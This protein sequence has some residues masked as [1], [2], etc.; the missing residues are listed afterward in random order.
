MLKIY[1]ED[2]S[3]AE[4]QA[5]EVSDEVHI[6]RLIPALVQEM[7]LPLLDPVGNRIAYALRRLTDGKVLPGNMSLRSAGVQSET[8][9]ALETSQGGG[10]SPT[11][12]TAKSW[13]RTTPAFQVQADNAIPVLSGS[14][15]AEP[16]QKAGFYSDQTIGDIDSFSVLN[17][18][19]PVVLPPPVAQQG[20]PVIPPS[21]ALPAPGKRRTRRMFF[22]LTGSVLG[23]AGAG[24][25]Y[26]AYNS[27]I[28]NG[29]PFLS[30]TGSQMPM[31]AGA[32]PTSA[33]A[34]TP[35]AAL[36]TQAKRLLTFAQHQQT[37]RTVVWSPDGTMLASGASDRL[38]LTWDLNKQIHLRKPQGGTVRVVS[39]SSDGAMLASGIG[40][41]I[42][43]LNAQSG[44]TEARLRTHRA[45]V[46]TL[47][48]SPK[49]PQMLVS[50]GMDRLAIVWNTQTFKAQ[51]L[52]RLHTTGI[53][54][55]SWAS[56]DSTVATSSQGG[57]IRVW[58]AQNG[59]Q[60]HGFYSDGQ[61]ATD[62]LSFNPKNTM[63]AVGSADGVVRLWQNGLACQ[64]E[65]NGQQQGQCTDMPQRLQGHKNVIR[66]VSWSPD[67]RFLATA[68]DDGQLLVWYPA[69]GATP[70]L[71][72]QQDAPILALSWSPDSKK[73]ATASGTTVTLWELM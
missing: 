55:A 59:Q 71:K 8:Y 15:S 60:V 21:Q 12:A 63:L 11:Q 35:R 61:Q 49:Q 44:V 67:G 64:V 2:N 26:A 6:S 24:L 56:D 36:P 37:V 9:F 13:Q 41:Q 40:N 73:L 19:G 72:V 66:A 70:L 51:T 17:N 3:F 28:G 45:Q 16:S 43:C 50:A 39:W 1:I 57:V 46:T 23:A 32:T 30:Q 31:T 20:V 29:L 54:A 4:P 62:A 68:G 25:A 38:L 33:S 47:A 22:L 5:M 42:L 52:F 10:A 7:G 18:A 34:T 27:F 14:R 65:G 48:W 58:T 53:L 69:Q